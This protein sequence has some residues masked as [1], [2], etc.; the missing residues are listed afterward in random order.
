MISIRQIQIVV[1][2]L[3]AACTGAGAADVPVMSDTK[4]I[5]VPLTR[6]ATDYTCGAAAVQSVIGFYGENIRESALAKELHTT[7]TVG[8]A[9]KNILSFAKR[10]GYKSSVYRNCSLD[11]LTK[12]VDAGTPVIC[13]IQAWPER[14][15]HYATDWED[16]HYVVAVG[17]DTANI[18]FM[19][20]CTLGKYTFIPR[21]EFLTRWHDTDG[22][23]KLVHFAMTLTKP[24]QHHNPD[25]IV[26]MD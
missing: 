24:G 22:K 17:H 12:L 14:K 1:C 3:V 13:L 15:V 4:L 10:H 19:D 2:A 5:K 16:G 11:S 18:Y 9:Y 8:T 25:E 20:P 21:Q 23:E 26:K 7:P 6:Q